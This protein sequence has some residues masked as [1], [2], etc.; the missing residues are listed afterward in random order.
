MVENTPS[1]LN[2]EFVEKVLRNSEA[3]ETIQVIDV[4][5][6]P[7]TNK[8]DNYG[9]EMLR[10]NVDLAKGKAH[11]RMTEKISFVVKMYPQAEGFQRDMVGFYFS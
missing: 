5:I 7:A 2:K 11:E 4:F 10:V 6:A 1:W 9:S 8:G 3:D